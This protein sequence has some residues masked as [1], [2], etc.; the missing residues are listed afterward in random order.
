M[1]Q[2]RKIFASI[3]IAIMLS[4]CVSIFSTNG[5]YAA[6]GDARAACSNAGGAGEKT[7]CVNAYETAYKSGVK[8]ANCSSKSSKDKTACELG[9]KAGAKAFKD[10]VKLVGTNGA[11]AGKSKDKTCSKYK[12]NKTNLKT[13]N[14]AWTAQA[15]VI[16]KDKGK[17]AKS[18]DDCKGVIGG[19]KAVKACK[20]AFQDAKNTAANKPVKDCAGVSTF[21]EFNCSTD[22]NTAKGGRENPIVSLMLTILAWVSGLVALATVG[23]I[24]YGGI[25]YTT[26]QDNAAQTQK[27]IMYVVDSVIGLI[28]WFSAFALINFIVPGGLF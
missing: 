14:D 16:A 6:K 3:F 25:L 11:S 9:A 27:G 26:A 7:S 18:E 13:C 28:L 23:A 22:S 24:V 4:F 20:E 2:T 5:T 19:S 17:K 12:K 15:V 10:S 1:K 21:F 8:A